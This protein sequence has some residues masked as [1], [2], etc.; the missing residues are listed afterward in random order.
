MIIIKTEAR[1]GIKPIKTFKIEIFFFRF[2]LMA[3]IKTKII[4][5]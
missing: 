4:I 3:P 5:E 2:Q 1:L